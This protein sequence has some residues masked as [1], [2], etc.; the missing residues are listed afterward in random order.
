MIELCRYSYHDAPPHIRLQLVCQL[1][2][3]ATAP[4]NRIPAH[5]QRLAAGCLAEIMEAVAD[6]TTAQ[7]ANTCI[8]SV[9]ASNA[10]ALLQEV[11]AIFLSSF[12]SLDDRRRAKRML[13]LIEAAMR[14]AHS[15]RHTLILKSLEHAVLEAAPSF[16][17]DCTTAIDALRA[18]RELLMSAN[19]G[20]TGR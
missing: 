7:L 10:R 15:R 4:D 16:G 5:M 6:G 17:V 11:H 2:E 13:D 20:R 8:T 1:A 14:S 18:I 9:L 19:R 12:P 3:L